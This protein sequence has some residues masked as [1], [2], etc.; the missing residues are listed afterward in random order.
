MPHK[1]GM[2]EKLL[3]FPSTDVNTCICVL[4]NWKY[5][6]YIICISIQCTALVLK[7]NYSV[8]FSL[9]DAALRPFFK[10][11]FYFRLV[12]NRIRCYDGVYVNIRVYTSILSLMHLF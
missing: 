10:S 12:E 9:G 6:I 4:Y 7:K 2:K 3:Y 5:S 1:N 8:E 11:E